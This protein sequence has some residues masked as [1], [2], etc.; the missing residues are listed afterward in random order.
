LS[1]AAIVGVLNSFDPSF[2]AAVVD[3]LA[4]QINALLRQSATPLPLAYQDVEEAHRTAVGLRRRLRMLVRFAAELAN[5]FVLS[6]PAM[7]DFLDLFLTTALDAL[8]VVESGAISAPAEVSKCLRRADFFA[9]LACDALPWCAASLR[10]LKPLDFSSQFDAFQRFFDR[11]DARPPAALRALVAAD[12]PAALAVDGDID[13]NDALHCERDALL[14]RWERL[15]AQQENAWVLGVKQ[16]SVHSELHEKLQVATSHEISNRIAVPPRESD[17]GVMYPPP[18]FEF[19]LMSDADRAPS[20]AMPPSDISVVREY[21][22]DVLDSFNADHVGAAKF[23]HAM[24]LPEGA[25]ED[26]V[27]VETIFTEMLA[28]PLPSFPLPFYT[29]VLGNVCQRP[30][31]TAPKVLGRLALRLWKHA[32]VLDVGVSDRF[33]R[34]LAL[35]LSNFDYTWAWTKWAQTMSLPEDDPKRLMVIEVILACVRLS[36]V[37]HIQEKLPEPLHAVLPAANATPVLTFA[38]DD[39]ATL[40]HDA[41]ASKEGSRG[42]AR[43]MA[44]SYG[45]AGLAVLLDEDAAA[46]DADAAEV[47]SAAAQQRRLGAFFEAM[48]KAGQQ[49]F[50]HLLALIERYQPIA[51]RL[52]TV[53]GALARRQVVDVAIGLWRQ[54]PQT[55]VLVLDRLQS[56]GIIDVVAV[57]DWAF[58]PAN[59]SHVKHGYV[60]D[61]V[62]GAVRWAVQ[63]ARLAVE[64][65]AASAAAADN[66]NELTMVRALN[67][68]LYALVERA[69]AALPVAANESP[70]DAALFAWHCARCGAPERGT[71]WRAAAR[72]TR[73][74]RGCRATRTGVSICMWCVGVNKKREAHIEKNRPL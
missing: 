68:A 61:I 60:R 23:L 57:V 39:A 72:A 10:A 9:A 58:D 18:A 16:N 45:G 69:A 26:A 30:G 53:G 8:T 11:R 41:M 7:L 43:I 62:R 20:N 21:V 3:A 56:Y 66:S 48:L 32:A 67:D 54:S 33:V 55:Q 35:H 40:L 19:E 38:N 14:V 50:S 15:L 34:W 49:S 12:D 74:D 64:A 6:A 44:Q 28:L 37:S 59:V 51:K 47:M 25:S 27:V 65:T 71:Y 24:P 4:E 22:R 13:P 5:S 52:V 46:D 73:C 42:V 36:Y 29:A 63:S 70:C 1:N 31:T 17:S 2:G